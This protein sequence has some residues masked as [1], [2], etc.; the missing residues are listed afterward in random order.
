MPCLPRA[1]QRHEIVALDGEDK[2]N[3][4]GTHEPQERIEQSGTWEYGGGKRQILS[5]MIGTH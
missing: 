3:L 2:E 4:Q 1:G 5:L